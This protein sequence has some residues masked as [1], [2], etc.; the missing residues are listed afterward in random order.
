MFAD[1]DDIYRDANG[2]QWRGKNLLLRNVGILFLN[3]FCVHKVVIPDK[4]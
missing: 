3:G 4:H 2:R 1:K